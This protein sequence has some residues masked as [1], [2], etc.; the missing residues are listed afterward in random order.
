MLPATETL[1]L[2]TTMFGEDFFLEPNRPVRLF[3]RR[4][5]TG[6][7]L[8][9]NWRFRS[10]EPFEEKHKVDAACQQGVDPCSRTKKLRP[11]ISSRRSSAGE[12]H[13]SIWILP[14]GSE[15]HFSLARPA[16]A[17]ADLEIPEQYQT[18]LRLA[19]LQH[20]RPCCRTY[21]NTSTVSR[22]GR[23]HHEE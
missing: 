11:V 3:F 4:A 15:A 10:L 7:P 23:Q 18:F 22:F 2:R 20:A 5:R 9:A 6:S 12:S 8:A 21:S 14:S 19:A 17:H 1:A 16:V 13:G